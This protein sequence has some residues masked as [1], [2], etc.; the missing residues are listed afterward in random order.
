MAHQ[1]INTGEKPHWCNECGEAFRKSSTL[2]SHQRIHTREKPYH[3]NKWGKSFRYISFAGHQKTHSEKKVYWC[4][5]CV[6]VFM[7]NLMDMRIHTE[8]KAYYCK[9]Y[10]KAFRH[11]SGL[12]EHQRIYM[13]ENLRNVMKVGRLF[14]KVQPLNNIRKFITK[15]HQL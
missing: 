10:G 7:K 1:K 4:N 8:Q 2:I 13:E 3:G 14:P 9:K 15:S 6:K 5:D 12:A 11:S